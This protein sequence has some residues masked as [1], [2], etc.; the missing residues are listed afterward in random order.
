[1]LDPS[2]VGAQLGRLDGKDRQGRGVGEVQER[3]SSESLHPKA[4]KG[5]LKKRRVTVSLPACPTAAVSQPSN[6]P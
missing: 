3:T 5:R 6:E 2:K 4:E 1:M